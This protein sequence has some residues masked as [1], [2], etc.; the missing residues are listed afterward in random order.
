MKHFKTALL[1]TALAGVA[2]GALASFALLRSG[3]LPD[4]QQHTAEEWP[5]VVARMEGHMAAMGKPVLAGA[6]SRDIVGFL[7]RHGRAQP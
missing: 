4:P 2:V 7:Q 5:A 3:A 6:H 1:I